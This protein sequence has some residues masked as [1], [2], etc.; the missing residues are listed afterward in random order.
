MLAYL[1]S[2]FLHSQ[3]THAQPSV[4]SNSANQR[5]TST[6]KQE[7][8]LI[9][10]SA[11]LILITIIQLVGSVIS[12]STAEQNTQA[13]I[14]YLRCNFHGDNSTCT[15]KQESIPIKIAFYRVAAGVNMAIPWVLFFYIVKIESFKKMKEVC[16]SKTIIKKI[17]KL[18]CSK[19]AV[20]Q[21]V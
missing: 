15:I 11:F 3:V 6:G 7:V 18:C 10:L 8:K 2:S 21:N 20:E 19:K 1:S 13:M 5:H 16:C 12:N 4:S 14:E 17:E 9:V